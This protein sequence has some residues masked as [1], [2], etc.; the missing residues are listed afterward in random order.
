[1]LKLTSSA[2]T[3]ALLGTLIV[4]A[5]TSSAQA[6][7][8][9]YLVMDHNGKNWGI[10]ASASARKMSKA[11]ERARRRCNRR[12]ERGFRRGEVGRGA[13]CRRMEQYPG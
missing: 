2:T 8:C 4:V 10:D 6:A 7:R 11:C 1:M 12:L 9:H 3:A 13:K 5:G